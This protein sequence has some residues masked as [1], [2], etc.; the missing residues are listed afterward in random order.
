[1]KQYLKVTWHQLTHLLTP[2][3]SLWERMDYQGYD[4]IFNRK[5]YRAWCS[6]GYNRPT[7]CDEELAVINDIRKNI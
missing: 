4:L 2:G 1:V 5:K 7:D 3:H 6:C